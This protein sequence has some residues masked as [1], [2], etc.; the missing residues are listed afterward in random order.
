MKN[1]STFLYYEFCA[2]PSRLAARRPRSRTPPLLTQTTRPVQPIFHFPLLIP[3]LVLYHNG[4]ADSWHF[5]NKKQ[6]IEAR[7]F[8][9]L[10]NESIFNYFRR[11]CQVPEL[12]GIV[13]VK[14][15]G[16][17]YKLYGLIDLASL[18]KVLSGPSE[19][20]PLQSWD[21]LAFFVPF[22]KGGLFSVSLHSG[23]LKVAR[24][25]VFGYNDP[26]F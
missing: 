23:S 13:R 20:P 21:A 19:G 2:G 26:A 15:E 24:Y 22:V 14:V 12:A 4:V 11:H 8:A 10:A 16:A 1:I 5:S 7:P 3:D 18:E 6:A 17:A 25:E 9:Q